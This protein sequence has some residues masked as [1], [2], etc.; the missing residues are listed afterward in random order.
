VPALA[1]ATPE[2]EIKAGE[3][4]EEIDEEKLVAFAKLAV[5]DLLPTIDLSE[6]VEVPEPLDVIEESGT[7]DGLTNWARQ[8]TRR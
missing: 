3:T 7:R 1:S 2:V 5:R 4:E 8:R 6:F